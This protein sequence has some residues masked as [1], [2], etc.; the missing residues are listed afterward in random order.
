L[1]VAYREILIDFVLASLKDQFGN[2]SL[3][4]RVEAAGKAFGTLTACLMQRTGRELARVKTED[5]RYTKIGEHRLKLIKDIREQIEDKY[6]YKLE[7]RSE[8]LLDLAEAWSVGLNERT[9]QVENRRNSSKPWR[10]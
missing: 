4:E 2:W 5:A 3:Q 6:G 8:Q 7:H 10:I 1:N 9:R